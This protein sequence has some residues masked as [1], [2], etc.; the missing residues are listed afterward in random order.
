MCSIGA[1]SAAQ[2]RAD[3]LCVRLFT[4]MR[5]KLSLHFTL[6]FPGILFIIGAE[7]RDHTYSATG[8]AP[9]PL[10]LDERA[11]HSFPV[12]GCGF[13]IAPRLRGI[14]EAQVVDGAEKLR[15]FLKIHAHLKHQLA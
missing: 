7:H 10:T 2:C 6:R 14:A 15:E 1:D 3:R 13:R 12:L 5:R 8:I 9:G 11:L 4:M